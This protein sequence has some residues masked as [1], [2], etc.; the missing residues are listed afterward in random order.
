M[1]TAV[2]DASVSGCVTCSKPALDENVT[3]EPETALL[4]LSLQSAVMVSP[5]VAALAAEGN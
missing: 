1:A 3:V 2:P 5:F 4:L